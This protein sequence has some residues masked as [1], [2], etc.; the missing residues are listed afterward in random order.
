MSKAIKVMRKPQVVE[1]WQW[2]GSNEGRPD[3]LSW[4]ISD[5]PHGKWFVSYDRSPDSM[6]G[7]YDESFKAYFEVVV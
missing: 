1:A 4:K 5:M 2:N 7:Y 3:W 6:Y